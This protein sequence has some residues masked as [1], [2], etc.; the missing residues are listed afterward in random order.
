VLAAYP[1]DTLES[2]YDLGGGDGLFLSTALTAYPLL[3]GLLLEQAYVAP[4]ARTRL[5]AA[6]LAER[7]E[8]I[9][10]DLFEA[11]PAGG[12]AYMLSRVIHD[13]ADPEAHQILV[14]C[15]RAMEDGTGSTGTTGS[16]T[17]N[18]GK[19]AN[20]TVLLLAERILPD[21]ISTDARSRAMAVSDLNMLVMTGGHERTLG[22]YRALLARAGFELTDCITQDT[23]LS[24][25]V[26]RS[27]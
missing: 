21:R 12:A 22:Q 25:L 19:H 13:W 6:G 15:R 1:F 18:G 4:R 5:A 27:V 24:L 17:G 3:R 2:L 8:V 10:G 9:E 26:A 23:A 7:C 11:V 20:G 16:T 14:N